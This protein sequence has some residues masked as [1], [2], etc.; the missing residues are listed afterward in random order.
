MGSYRVCP[1]CKRE[2]PDTA[3]AAPTWYTCGTCRQWRTYETTRPRQR[4]GELDC[5]ADSMYNRRQ[6]G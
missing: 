6:G 1:D 2:E 5:S 3:I 4:R